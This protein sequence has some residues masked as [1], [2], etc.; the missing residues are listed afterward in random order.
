[1][2][3]T[4]CPKCGAKMRMVC[5]TETGILLRCT[6]NPE[7]ECEKKFTPEEI[8]RQTFKNLGKSASEEKK[9]AE[10]ISKRER[11]EGISHE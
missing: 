3:M 4:N 6:K 2:N 10:R 11:K 8:R 9:R 7:H 1:M 5:H